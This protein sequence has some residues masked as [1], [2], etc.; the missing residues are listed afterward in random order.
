MS[1][2]AYPLQW[3]AGR[4][5]TEPGRQENGRFDTTFV[6]ARNFLVDELRKLTS[7]SPLTDA[8]ADWQLKTKSAKLALEHAWLNPACVDAQGQQEMFR[9]VAA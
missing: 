9:G 7:G 3:P 6:N 4:K 8:L 2:N 1:T 5:R